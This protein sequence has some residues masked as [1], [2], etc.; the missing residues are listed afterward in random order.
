MARYL[1]GIDLGT[2]NCA[3]A[4]VDLENPSLAIELFSIPQLFTPTKITSLPTLSSCCYLCAPEELVEGQIEL[5]WKKKTQMYVGELA[6]NL[7]AR[8]P[9]KLVQSAKSWLSHLGANRRDKILPLH[10]AALESRLSPVEAS[11]NYLM[12]LRDAWNYLKAKGE[13]NLELEEQEI[14]LTVPASFD[15]TARTLTVEAAKLAGF[16]HVTLLEEPQAAFYSWIAQN[17]KKCS[18][19]A[20]KELILVCDVGGGTTDFS[21]IEANNLE[22]G[23]KFQ[24][25]AVGNHLLLGGDNIDIALAR[26]IE[27][28][29]A[30]KSFSLDADQWLQLV[31]QARSAKEYLLNCSEEKEHFYTVVVQGKGASVIKGSLSLTLSSQEVKKFVLEGFFG[32]YSLQEAAK[33]SKSSGF[34][35]MGLPYEAEPSIIKQLANFIQQNSLSHTTGIDYLLFNGGAM[36]PQIFQQAILDNLNRWF[37]QKTVSLLSSASLD[38]AVAKGAAYYAKVRH[39]MGVA[40]K[41]GLSR[42]YYLEIEDSAPESSHRKAITLL[43]RGAQEGATFQSNEKFL[44]RANMPVAF[45]LLTSQTRLNDKE[46]EFVIVDPDEFQILPPVETVLR[47]GKQAGKEMQDLTVAVT[48]AITLTPVGTIEIWLKSLQTDHRWNLEFQLRSVSGQEDSLASLQKKRC[49]QTFEKGFLDASKK[50]LQ[51][52]AQGEIRPAR[53]MEKLEQSLQMKRE[54]WPL[55][56][57]R[58]LFETLLH[59]APQCIGTSSMENRWWNL[60]GFLMRPGF[61]YPLDDFRMKELWKMMLGEIKKKKGSEAE[62]QKW[63]FIRRVA[64]GL[65]KGQQMQIAAELFPDLYDKKS[66]KIQEKK[67]ENHALYLEKIRAFA[68]LERIDLSL[69]TMFGQ[70]LVNK[71]IKKEGVETEYW[72]LGRI[73]ARHLFYGSAGQVL[74]QETCAKWIKILLESI[75]ESSEPFLFMLRQM[76]RKTDR[77]EL[78]LPELLIAQILQKFPQ[79]EL[80]KYLTKVETDPL[81]ESKKVFGETLPLGLM[82]SS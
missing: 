8:V 44:L 61:G 56:V 71:M 9:T 41:S 72:A 6:K 50:I 60:A 49:D 17:E 20:P 14:V 18:L 73:A 77:R 29:M 2:T 13:A 19:F 69:K 22:E 34:K 55:S 67:Q 66:K 65:N 1:I 7:G 75:K 5:P 58:G 59:L 62:L 52:F 25:M 51:Q 28:K 80:K 10:A 30:T 40:I 21:L 39:G 48:V 47:F 63:I 35:T 46:G 12:H 31:A 3:L 70:A 36:K 57:I 82:L 23:L 33:L 4:F 68:A 42:T 15:E 32:Q 24:R 76:A 27:Q 11:A 79:Q 64:G 26:Y 54:E 78:N 38:L 16:N 53:L 74:P 37:P 45:H 81:K 43:K